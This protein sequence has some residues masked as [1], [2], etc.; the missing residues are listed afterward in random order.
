MT[1]DSAAY[2]LTGMSLPDGWTVL[3][4]FDVAPG[5]TGGACSVC[6]LAERS[7]GQEGFLKAIDYAAALNAH[8]PPAEFASLTNRFNAERDLH[9]QCGTRKLDRVVRALAHGTVR[10]PD[11]QPDA[12]SYLIFER[13]KGDARDAVSEVDAADHTPMLGIAHNAAVGISQLHG[14]GAAHQDVKPSNILFWTPSGAGPEAKVGD[15]GCSFQ[16]GRPAPQDDDRLA[17]DPGYAAPEQLYEGGGEWAGPRWRTAAD[18]YMLGGLVCYLLTGVPFNGLFAMN[19]D[20]SLRWPN[21]GGTFGDVLPAL[22]DAHGMATRRLETALD[23]RVALDVADVVA[24]LCYPDPNLRG[25][26]KAR[27]RGQDPFSLTRYISRLN[28]IHRRAAY[29]LRHTA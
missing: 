21:W 5:K 2:R 9:G 12:V 29:S 17:G 26:A 10:V 3:E 22:A 25:D 7:D 24:Q 1:D 11:V 18:M 23:Q 4:R 13:A 20:P 16:R 28:L 8:D 27:G 15:L 19:L 14:I 6:Y